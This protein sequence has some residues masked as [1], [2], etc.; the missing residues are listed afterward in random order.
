ME[1]REQI[2]EEKAKLKNEILRM[3][4]AMELI[5]FN[6]ELYSIINTELID[7][8]KKLEYLNKLI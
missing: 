1:T 6:S 2:I 3:S 7:L 4:E 8:Y 5:S